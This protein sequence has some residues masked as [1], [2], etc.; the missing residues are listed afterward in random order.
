MVLLLAALVMFGIYRGTLSLLNRLTQYE[1]VAYLSPSIPYSVLLLMLFVMLCISNSVTAVGALFLSQDIELILSSPVSRLRFFVTKFVSL[2]LYTSWM[3]LTFLLP[4]LVAYGVH[5]QASVDYY[6]FSFLMLP[7]FFLIPASLAVSLSIIFTAFIPASKTKILLF[8]I[9]G[10]I[11]ACVFALGE[12]IGLGYQQQ[13]SFDQVARILTIV[14]LPDKLWLPTHW[15]AVT[16]RD[17]LENRISDIGVPLLLL[18]SL[19]L[20]MLFLSYSIFLLLYEHAYSKS[21]DRKQ[22]L[23]TRGKFWWKLFARFAPWLSSEKRAIVLKEYRVFSRDM[24]Q[25]I[26][27]LLLAG[28]YLIYLYN[29]RVLNL[30]DSIPGEKRIFWQA[31]AYIVNV[32]MGAFVTTAAATRLVFPSISLEGQ[33]F[34][35]LQTAPYDMRS[36]LQVKFWSW[37]IPLG[38]IATVV[39][40]SGAFAIKT[41]PEGLAIT[42][43]SAWILSAGIVGM[44]LGL[45]AFFANFQWEHSGQLAASFGSF[46][47]M[48]SSIALIA[49]SMFPIGIAVFMREPGMFGQHLEVHWWYLFIVASCAFVWAINILARE[50]ALKLGIRSLEKL[51]DQ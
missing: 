38:T 42:F 16:M 34:W 33:G 48:L 40:C 41:S 32:A 7:L 26:Q 22:V 15:V 20:G 19:V 24:P 1:Q 5:F 25:V 28:V 50:Y 9:L 2:L 4:F 44:G 14:S 43:F 21:C 8:A 17:L 3:P 6:L 39:F 10:V 29:L 11:L 35:M 27:V 45:G 36:F 30:I 31:F 49:V 51:R 47:F 12:V 37:F 13:N 46:V 18:G 23:M